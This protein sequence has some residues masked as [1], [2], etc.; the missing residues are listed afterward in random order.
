[1]RLELGNPGAGTK[2]IIDIPVYPDDE[3]AVARLVK[4]G[5]V[6]LKTAGDTWRDWSL[7]HETDEDRET[8]LLM[9]KNRV[10]QK[11]A[12]ERQNLEL[13]QMLAG[14]PQPNRAARRAAR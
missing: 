11:Q 12:V 13:E 1:M 14:E 7:E 4:E 8:R 9:E 10:L 2:V 6:V 3:D 5:L